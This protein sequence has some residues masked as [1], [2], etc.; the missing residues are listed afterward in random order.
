[1]RRRGNINDRTKHQEAMLNT[2]KLINKAKVK[3]KP[4]VEKAPTKGQQLKID[5]D[6]LI[7]RVKVLEEH[8]AGLRAVIKEEENE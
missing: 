2:T 5:L 7:E 4:V 3:P 1:M 8:Q 6:A